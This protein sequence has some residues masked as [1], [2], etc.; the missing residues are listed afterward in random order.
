MR[1]N[2]NNPLTEQEM[3]LLSKE[4]FDKFLDYLDSKSAYLRK[5]A[6]DGLKSNWGRKVVETMARKK[7]I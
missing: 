3:E 2:P 7:I 4:D 6:E 1:Y 5:N